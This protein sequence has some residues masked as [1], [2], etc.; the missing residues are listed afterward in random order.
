M[1]N[2]AVPNSAMDRRTPGNLLQRNLSRVTPDTILVSNDNVIR[3]VCWFFKRDN[4]K[5]VEKTG[6]LTYGLKH[7][8]NKPGKFLSD[9]M[10]REM[11]REN[12]GK[13]P[14]ILVLIKDHFENYKDRLP[15]PSFTDTDNHFVFAVY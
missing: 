9:D 14:V 15:A 12:A 2:F 3:A 4:V 13:R 6:E 7:E 11:I 8:G 5:V 10:L 1:A